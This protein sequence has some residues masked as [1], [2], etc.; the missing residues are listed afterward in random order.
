MGPNRLVL[1]YERRRGGTK[2]RPQTDALRRSL[3]LLVLETLSPAPMP[4]AIGQH[5]QQLPE[6]A[7]E[8][9]ARRGTA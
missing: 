6:G 7:L 9:F 8:A 4:G 1:G 2:S 5:V 3:D